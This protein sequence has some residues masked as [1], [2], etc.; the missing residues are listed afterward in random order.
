MSNDDLTIILQKFLHVIKLQDEIIDHAEETIL[1]LKEE[2]CEILTTKGK[3]FY[4]LRY[5]NLR[6]DEVFT[7]LSLHSEICEEWKNKFIESLKKMG[8]FPDDWSF[9]ITKNP[10]IFDIENFIF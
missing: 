4:Q 1:V 5:T 10:E 7:K 6:T 2:A 8:H 3:E 9:E